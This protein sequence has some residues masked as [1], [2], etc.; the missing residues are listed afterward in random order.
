M[1]RGLRILWVAGAAIVAV[2]GATIALRLSGSPHS[3]A[4]AGGSGFL[5]AAIVWLLTKRAP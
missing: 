5:A 4:L 2:V 3:N 1:N